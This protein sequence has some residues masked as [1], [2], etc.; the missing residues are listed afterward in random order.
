MEGPMEIKLH[1]ASERGDIRAVQR[2]L[3]GGLQVNIKDENGE[4]PLHR[5]AFF[6]YSEIVDLLLKHGAS[7]D[8]RSYVTVALT[9][10]DTPLQLASIKG[11]VE[12][13]KLL[14]EHH[15]NVNSTDGL[16]LTPLH[17]AAWKGYTEIVKLLLE[18]GADVNAI[19]KTGM[20]PLNL[21]SNKHHTETV[22][23]LLKY[24]GKSSRQPKGGHIYKDRIILFL[25]KAKFVKNAVPVYLDY[26]ILA[27]LHSQA[28][29]C[30]GTYKLMTLFRRTFNYSTYDIVKCQCLSCKK[31]RFFPFKP[32]RIHTSVEQLMHRWVKESSS[33]NGS[34]DATKLRAKVAA[35][36]SKRHRLP[37]ISLETQSRCEV[38]GVPLGLFDRLRGNRECKTCRRQFPGSG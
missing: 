16:L 18:H 2:I 24:G 28:C 27:W 34:E 25:G 11:H 19:N 20:T 31:T 21:A 32:A 26:D 13:V 10:G 38:C 5:A 7:V 1:E 33:D 15:A 14:L 35:L 8:A 17:S 29:K 12:I 9:G 3:K 22:N 37:L 4:T 23:L 6:G 36:R 30:G